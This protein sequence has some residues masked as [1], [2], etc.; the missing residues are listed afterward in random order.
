MD[1]RAQELLDFWLNEVGEDGWYR[2]D[3]A[4]DATIRER[5]L[6][7]WEEARAGALVEWTVDPKSTLALLV[8]LDQFPRNMFRGSP[9]SY[10]TDARAVAVAKEAA[11]RGW[12]RRIP[13]PERQFMYMPLMHSEVQ[14]EQDKA[15]RLFLIS[16]GRGE[17][18][19]HARCHRD[20]IRRFGRFPFR[21]APL[22]RESTPEE[23][24]F[25]EA[26]AYRAA[27]EATP[28]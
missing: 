22:G 2:Q 28:P 15:V 7:L 27:Y 26:G 10:A 18:L 11:L 5:W 17:Y 3:E 6:G 25:L 4:Q 21:N 23:V 13:L 1:P 12:D 16:F 8:L 19:R 14:V 20:I 24:A 9:L